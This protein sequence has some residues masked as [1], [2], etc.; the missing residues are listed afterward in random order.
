MNIAAVSLYSISSPSQKSPVQSEAR[1]ASALLLQPETGDILAMA[2]Y[3]SYDPQRI[4]KSSANCRRNR[5]ITDIFE[6]GSTFKLVTVA[7]CLE[8][9]VASPAT[10][11]TAEKELELAGG[12]RLRDK[13]DY[14]DVTV[15]DAV[16]R[17]IT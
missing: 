8:E 1:A 13:E 16:H 12:H 7:A 3:P 2:S 4:A 11:L 9:G 17:S 10:L 6:P 5:A 14:G 15:A